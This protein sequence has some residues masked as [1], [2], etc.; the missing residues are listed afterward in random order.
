MTEFPLVG[1]LSLYPF[2]YNGYSGDTI[3][4]LKFTIKEKLRLLNQNDG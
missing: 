2:K 4:K 1:D 3:L